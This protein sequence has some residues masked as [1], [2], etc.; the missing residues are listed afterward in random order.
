MKV[1]ISRSIPEKGIEILKNAGLEVDVYESYEAITRK[2]FISKL[3]KNKYDALLCILTEKIDK[4]VFDTCPTL[5]IVSNYAVGYDNIDIELAKE[6]GVVVT[7]T[8]GVLTD[9]VA[10]HTVALITSISRRVVESDVFLREGLYK[11]WGPKLFL[12]TEIKGKTLGIV[13]AGRIGTRVAEIMK[14]GF[15]VNV[16]Y[17]S[18]SFSERISSI[19]G[20]QKS[21]D[22][23]LLESDFVSIHLPLTSETKHFIDREKINKMKSTAYLINTSRGPIIKEDDLSISLIEGKIMGAALDVFENE[24]AVNTK[25]LKLKN[26]IMTPHTASATIETRTKMSELAATNIVHFLSK[27][28]DIHRVA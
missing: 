25:L 27:K 16:I 6:R 5:K 22:E 3:K 20:K 9:A 7:N 8:P 28:G 24:P 18:T 11:S 14:N 10:E 13:G 4:E 2:E 15:G 26:I 1:F 19:G 21:I 17:Y 12:G 23:L